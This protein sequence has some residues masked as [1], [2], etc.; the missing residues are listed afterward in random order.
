MSTKCRLVGAWLLSGGEQGS[1]PRLL[2]PGVV[3]GS[4]QCLPGVQLEGAVR[5][6]LLL[7]WVH[8]LLSGCEGPP[9]HPVAPSKSWFLYCTVSE[10]HRVCYQSS[11][12]LTL[13]S[14]VSDRALGCGKSGGTAPVGIWYRMGCG[15]LVAVLQVPVSWMLACGVCQ[16]Q[17]LG[18]ISPVIR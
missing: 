7:G 12:Q 14:G 11:S 8:K 6:M 10:V 1:L 18:F 2:P 9:Y 4:T 3:T 13:I 16:E 15:Q 17:G 5:E